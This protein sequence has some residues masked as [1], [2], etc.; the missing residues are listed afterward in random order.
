MP[1]FDFITLKNELNKPISIKYL[2]VFSDSSMFRQSNVIAAEA[3]LDKK[4]KAW[5]KIEPK[6][7]QWR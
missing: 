3:M 1:K 2:C 6:V 4:I 5:R 7:L